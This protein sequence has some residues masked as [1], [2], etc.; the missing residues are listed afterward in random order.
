MFATVEKLTLASLLKR[1]HKKHGHVHLV[2]L[3]RWVRF[4]LWTK[5]LFDFRFHKQVRLP[6]LF[7]LIMYKGQTSRGYGGGEG[8]LAGLTCSLYTKREQVLSSSEN[9]QNWAARSSAI[10]CYLG[11]ESMIFQRKKLYLMLFYNSCFH[12]SFQKCLLKKY[13]NKSIPIQNK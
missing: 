9:P 11:H 2:G 10:S 3:Y 1:Y 5:Y 8:V 13:G 4:I 7:A 12:N 6:K